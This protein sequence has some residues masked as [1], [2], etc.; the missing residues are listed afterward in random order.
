MA[1]TEVKLEDRN[2]RDELPFISIS[3]DR[4]SFGAVFS[5]LAEID[6][7]YRV[8]LFIDEEMLRVGF[9]FHTKVKQNSLALVADGRTKSKKFVGVFC[10]SHNIVKRYPWIQA[11]T[12]LPSRDRRFHPKKEAGKWVI[13]LCPSF[14]I[15]NA[16]ESMKIPEDATGVYR[17]VRE[18]GEVVYIGRGNIRDRLNSP[19]R[20]SWD[21]DS[22]EYSLVQDP[23][24]QIF[25]E[26]YWIE[27]YKEQNGKLPFH[28]KV[29]GAKQDSSDNESV[30]N[31][32]TKNGR[33]QI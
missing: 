23:D 33:T 28:N 27:K 32:T 21:F 3:R 10:S 26:T 17:Y 11:I 25:W 16:R 13:D 30:V 9:E 4:I 2:V 6:P 19:E 22:I 20:S 12:S 15:R 14:E 18:N 24:R 1:W 5:R 29:S 31:N 7:K 8:S